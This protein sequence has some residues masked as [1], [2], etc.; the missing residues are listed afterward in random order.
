MLKIVVGSEKIML[1]TVDTVNAADLMELKYDLVFLPYLGG[2]ELD[3]FNLIKRI[4]YL[5]LC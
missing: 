5:L 3:N 2:I 4:L 1:V